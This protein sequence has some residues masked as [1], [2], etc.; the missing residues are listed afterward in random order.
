MPERRKY[1]RPDRSWWGRT[2]DEIA[3]RIATFTFNHIATQWYSAMIEGSIRLGIKAAHEE[4]KAEA[5]TVSIDWLQ[6][7]AAKHDAEHSRK[8]RED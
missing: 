7:S 2:R 3:F 6:V 8:G 1:P 4:A 5:P